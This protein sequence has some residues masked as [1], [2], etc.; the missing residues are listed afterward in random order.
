MKD[1]KIDAVK[2]AVDQLKAVPGQDTEALELLLEYARGLHAQ[3]KGLRGAL[4]E[5]R[6]Y[7]LMRNCSCEGARKCDRCR[8]VAQI[9]KVL[10]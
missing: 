7:A 2:A 10:G 8:M 1:A 5:A 4:V 9:G 3:A 6:A